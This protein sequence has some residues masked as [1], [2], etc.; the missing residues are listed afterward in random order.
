MSTPS[1][2]RAVYTPSDAADCRGNAF[3][4]ALPPLP[5]DPRKLADMLG[6]TYVSDPGAD[7][8]ARD[9]L[10]DRIASSSFICL[11]RNVRLFR[12]VDALLREGYRLRPASASGPFRSFEEYQRRARHRLQHLTA[13]HQGETAHQA[14]YLSLIGCHGSGKTYALRRILSFYPQ[15]IF[16]HTL[17][18]E[19][20]PLQV[21]YLHISCGKGGT[22]R[23]LCLE[24][25]DA[26]A[27]L[28][29]QNLRALLG[30]PRPNAVFLR[31]I[32]QRLMAHYH[33]GL[34][35]IDQ[36]ENLMTG[37]TRRDELFAFITSLARRLDTPLLLVAATRVLNHAR[38]DGRVAGIFDRCQSFS[39]QR[40]T[41][42]GR[43]YRSFLKAMWS[44][45]PLANDPGHVP[46]E[47]EQALY[48][49]SQG[50]VTHLVSL[51]VLS[52]KVALAQNSCYLTPAHVRQS[53]ELYFDEVRGKITALQDHDRSA[54]RRA[55]SQTFSTEQFAQHCAMLSGK[56]RSLHGRPQLPGRAPR[57]CAD[58]AGDGPGGRAETAQPRMGRGCARGT[59]LPEA[60]G[61]AR[62]RRGQ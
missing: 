33:V 21:V 57:D 43:C 29:G 1:Y 4:E 52:V 44:Q 47:F 16:H 46:R 20:D 31:R 36:L 24:I 45:Q 12:A 62:Q 14:S 15:V 30:G 5:H 58:A 23:E 48:Y 39:W 6:N 9:A 13:G 60:R 41:P 27:G 8:V 7:A 35:V 49:Y 26:L 34:L 11:P 59:A 50:I 38:R 3:I 40:L 32:V 17:G 51:F 10:A 37:R 2:S 28:T 25:I 18:G 55:Q 42:G 53:Y 22:V 61:S 19:A 54:F 56:I